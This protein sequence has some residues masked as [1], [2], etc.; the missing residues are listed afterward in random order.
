M[1]ILSACVSGPL[2]LEMGQGA[3]NVENNLRQTPVACAV[4]I[5]HVYD[6]RSNK[7]TLGSIGS[8]TVYGK[9]VTLWIRNAMDELNALGYRTVPIHENQT[10]AVNIEMSLKRLY[11][12]STHST[13]ESVVQLN[14]RYA[15]NN[16]VYAERKYRGSDVR[17][18]WSGS[19]DVLKSFN[20]SMSQ[21]V[22]EIAKD[23]TNLCNV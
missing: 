16:A 2:V 10:R 8:S 18:N 17:I 20:Y 22:R 9:D 1:I 5:S 21:V 19:S 3:G 6:D 12:Q 15:D 7:Q 11:I 13:I 4:R 23:L 14:I